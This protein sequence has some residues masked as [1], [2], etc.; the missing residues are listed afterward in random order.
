V[1]GKGPLGQSLPAMLTAFG[2]PLPPTREAEDP[3]TMACYAGMSVADL[4]RIQPAAEVLGDLAR[5]L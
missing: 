5:P 3:P 4:T 1:R 2:V